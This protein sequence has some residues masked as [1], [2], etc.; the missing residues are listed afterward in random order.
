MY[1][2]CQNSKDVVAAQQAYL[3]SVAKE[4][5]QTGIAYQGKRAAV[6]IAFYGYVFD[7]F[8]IFF[9]HKILNLNTFRNEYVLIS[10]KKIQMLY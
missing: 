8:L 5:D 3:D 7:H 2:E 1:K 10:L 4:K 6:L 9:A